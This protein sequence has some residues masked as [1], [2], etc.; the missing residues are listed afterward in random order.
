MQIEDGYAAT[1]PDPCIP[2][3]VSY[4]L[5]P[6]LKLKICLLSVAAL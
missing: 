5:N 2:S 4:L 1:L 6:M 3:P